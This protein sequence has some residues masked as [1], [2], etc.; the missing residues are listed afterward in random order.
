ML[1]RFVNFVA[2]AEF[3]NALDAPIPA[4]MKAVSPEQSVSDIP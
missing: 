4:E 2:L 1:P 3:I